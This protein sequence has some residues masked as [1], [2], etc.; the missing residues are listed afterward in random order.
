MRWQSAS[1]ITVALALGGGC[2][3]PGAGTVSDK[4]IE[5]PGAKKPPT[6]ERETGPVVSITEFDF[7]RVL[8][9]GQTLQHDFV[10]K[11]R[12]PRPVRLAGVTSSRPCC[13]EIGPVPESIPPGG[14]VPLRLGLRPGYQYG[15]RGVTFTVGTDDPERPIRS[16]ILTATLLPEIEVRGEDVDA[17]LP[18]GAAGRRV[19]QIICRRQDGD[20]RDAPSWAKAAGPLNASFLGPASVATFP[21]GVV[22]ATRVVEV[23]IPADSGVGQ[24]RGELLLRWED[25]REWRHTL[26]W[27]VTP[28]IIAS[29]PGFVLESSTGRKDLR[30][31]LRSSDRAFRVLKVYGLPVAGSKYGQE[32]REVQQV[33]LTLDPGLARSAAAHDVWI[34]TDHPDQ[35]TIM[36][37]VLVPPGEEP[38]P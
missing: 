5:P 17:P 15:R 37:S 3:Q 7:G 21:G 24:R 32:P 19:I 27:R 1:L 29:P 13:S 12:S 8:A 34:E 2:T 16:F 31:I 36:L 35:P 11:N 28:R 33:D 9:R 23:S 30:A 14:E 4:A 26:T 10:I 22:E 18:V 6:A 20:G 38:R 25:G